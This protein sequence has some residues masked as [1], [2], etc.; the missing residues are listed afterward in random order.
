MEGSGVNTRLSVSRADEQ[1]P[2]K[3][4]VSLGQEA[5]AKA[6]ASSH[7]LLLRSRG[8]VRDISKGRAR[9]HQV[10][11]EEAN[12][13]SDPLVMCQNRRNDVDPRGSHNRT[14]SPVPVDGPDAVRREGDVTSMHALV[15][16]AGTC[17]PV[18]MIKRASCRARARSAGC[19]AG[20]ARPR[21][22]DETHVE[23]LAISAQLI[24]APGAGQPS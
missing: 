3:R 14:K 18:S 4:R 9:P 15:W 21:A 22:W 20:G 5:G 16:N 1:E 17:R 13:E 23:F 19:P 12:D 11:I 6:R 2:H 24:S 7:L 10:S 8:V